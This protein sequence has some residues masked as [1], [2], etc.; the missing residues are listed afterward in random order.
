MI[1]F[2]IVQTLFKFPLKKNNS[3]IQMLKNYAKGYQWGFF[4][5]N[6]YKNYLKTPVKKRSMFTDVE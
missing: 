5:L 4:L 1:P 2:N 3:T 6:A